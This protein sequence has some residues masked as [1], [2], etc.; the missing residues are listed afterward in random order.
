MVEEKEPAA[1]PGVAAD[2]RRRGEVY[3]LLQPEM[4]EPRFALFSP[5]HLTFTDRGEPRVFYP[6]LFLLFTLVH[7]PSMQTFLLVLSFAIFPSILRCCNFPVGDLYDVKI[8]V[9]VYFTVT[10]RHAV[11]LFTTTARIYRNICRAIACPTVA[12]KTYGSKKLSPR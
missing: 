4:F 10:V 11:P 6:L 5:N 12:D 2:G 1:Q 7:P 8:C 3:V 9:A